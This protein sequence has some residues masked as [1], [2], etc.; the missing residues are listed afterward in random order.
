LSGPPEK[1]KS[2]ERIKRVGSSR[3]WI[4]QGDR[5]RYT[6]RRWCRR[7]KDGSENEEIGYKKKKLDGQSKFP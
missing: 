6:W 4:D 2:I 3:H 1:R 5:K 7:A